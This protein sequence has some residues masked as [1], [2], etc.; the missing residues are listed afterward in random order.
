MAYYAPA[1]LAVIAEGGAAV[2]AAGSTASTWVGDATLSLGTRAM[3]GLSS[4]G[5]WVSSTAIPGTL[6]WITVSGTGV[7]LYLGQNWQSVT[8]LVIATINLGQKIQDQG[9]EGFFRNMNPFDVGWKNAGFNI[10]SNLYDFFDF[11]QTHLNNKQTYNPTGADEEPPPTPRPALPGASTDEET[12]MPGTPK[13]TGIDDDGQPSMPGTGR[14]GQT[15]P[16]EH[17]QPAPKPPPAKTALPDAD[18]TATAKPAAK[19]TNAD[20]PALTGK[21][22]KDE[23]GVQVPMIPRKSA[24]DNDMVDAK[25]GARTAQ[26]IEQETQEAVKQVAAIHMVEDEA[27]EL[28]TGQAVAAASGTK[29]AGTGQ[30]GKMTSTANQGTRSRGV[31]TASGTGGQT[32]LKPLKPIGL[33]PRIAAKFGFQRSRFIIQAATIYREEMRK[34]KHIPNIAQRSSLAHLETQKRMQKLFPKTAYSEEMTGVSGPVSAKG[35]IKQRR[36]DITRVEAKLDPAEDPRTLVL[37]LKAKAYV[38]KGQLVHSGDPDQMQAYAVL[39]DQ[40]GVPVVVIGSD[41]RIFSQ[42][43]DGTGWMKIGGPE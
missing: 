19:T 24:N 26:S 30:K 8:A 18:D 14:K 4:A 35:D 3:L 17:D 12:H 34:L 9:F 29:G 16:T 41:G 2:S 39:T 38:V 32:G 10:I 27:A 5:T 43:A 37:E 11:Y 1:A 23:Q 40:L 13:P 15:S 36:G 25:T 7:Y 22:K 31:P 42:K 28:Q 21:P 33:L 6:T 20:D